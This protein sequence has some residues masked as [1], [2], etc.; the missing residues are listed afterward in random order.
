M[1]SIYLCLLLT[2]VYGLKVQIEHFK[3]ARKFC[4]ADLVLFLLSPFNI[5]PMV[6]I[7]LVSHVVDIDKVLFE[8]QD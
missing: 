3:A 8:N 2:Y 5:I 7:R 1:I 6:V 4:V